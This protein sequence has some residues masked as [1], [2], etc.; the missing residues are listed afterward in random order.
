MDSWD[1]RPWAIG[2]LCKAFYQFG[3][4]FIY[5]VIDISVYVPSKSITL[6]IE[7]VFSAFANGSD[8]KHKKVRQLGS[9]LCT[10]LSLADVISEITR[11]QKFVSDE[12]GRGTQE[13]LQP[14]PIPGVANASPLAEAPPPVAAKKRKQATSTKEAPAAKK[15]AA[16]KK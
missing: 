5:R 12:R 9:T 4:G 13:R 2:G 1:T 8:R 7:P 14:V 11:L 3:D 10:P 6:T 15:K 16:K